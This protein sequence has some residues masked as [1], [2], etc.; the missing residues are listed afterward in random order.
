MRNH[1]E[2]ELLQSMHLGQ[3]LSW[4]LVNSLVEKCIR[5]SPEPQDQTNYLCS[6]MEGNFTDESTDITSTW[7]SFQSVK[8]WHSGKLKVA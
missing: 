7:T 6:S 5:W 8:W 3:C 1:S 2:T 4:V